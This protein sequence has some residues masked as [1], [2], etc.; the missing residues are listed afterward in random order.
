MPARNCPKCG[1]KLTKTSNYFCG[2]C[3][4]VLAD[5]LV[6]KP[7]I[8]NISIARFESLSGSYGGHI[9]KFVFHSKYSPIIFFVTAVM[10]V[11]VSFSNYSPKIVIENHLPEP[12]KPASSCQGEFTCGEFGSDRLASVIPESVSLYVEGFDFDKFSQFILDYD[13][14]YSNL[15]NELRYLETKH[16]ALFVEYLGGSYQW[17]VLLSSSKDPSAPLIGMINNSSKLYIGRMDN[18]YIISSRGNVLGD[19]QRTRDG[20][21]KALAH[22]SKY[23]IATNKHK[24]GQFLILSVNGDNKTLVDKIKNGDKVPVYIR[25]VLSQ[26]DLDKDGYLV[27]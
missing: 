18:L 20:I 27:F 16:I 12:A 17:T 6:L 7:T 1:N 22:N 5:S 19:L 2:S 24:E 23:A 13:S 21:T 4:D 11:Y 10:L 9:F 26:L 15:I 3:G 25:N 14:S 8:P